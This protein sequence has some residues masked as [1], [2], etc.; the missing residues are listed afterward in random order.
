MERSY[1]FVKNEGGGREITVREKRKKQQQRKEATRSESIK[2]GLSRGARK[3]LPMV[4]MNN[5]RQSRIKWR[6]KQ[7]WFL[8]SVAAE[9]R[10]AITGPRTSRTSH[11]SHHTRLL[12]LS[13][14]FNS[15]LPLSPF[16]GGCYSTGVATVPAQLDSR[17]SCFLFFFLL[18]LLRWSTEVLERYAYFYS[19]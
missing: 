16:P 2:I 17:A 8:T 14:G 5:S 1:S 18:L 4:G 12:L 6:E 10:T 7:K 3:F 15:V 11:F 9:T 13:F 19:R